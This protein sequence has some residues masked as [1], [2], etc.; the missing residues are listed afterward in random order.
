MRLFYAI[1]LDDKTRRLLQEKQNLLKSKALKANFSRIENLHLTLRFMGEVSEAYFPVMKKILESVAGKMKAF[2]LE[3]TE[4][5]LFE[6]G[7]KS[8]IWWGIRK[9]EALYRLQK[10]LEEEI[11]LH[12]FSLETK[13]YSPHITLAREFVSDHNIKELLQKLTWINH[14]FDVTGI[15]LMESTRVD[16]K[17]TY[18]RRSYS[19]LSSLNE[20]D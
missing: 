9:N 1:E 8:I 18:L 13:P 10:M 4:P 5:G 11:R 3:L 6:R 17:L 20:I 19:A 7:H 12:G 2:Q 15:S 14:P 16:G